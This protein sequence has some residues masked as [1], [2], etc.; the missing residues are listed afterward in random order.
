MFVYYLKLRIEE[1]LL[2]SLT[3]YVDRGVEKTDDEF[4]DQRQSGHNHVTTLNRMRL[5]DPR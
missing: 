5:N 3:R 4:F 2:S 1:R